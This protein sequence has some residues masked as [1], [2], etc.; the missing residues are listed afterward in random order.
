[1]KTSFSLR[2]FVTASALLLFVGGISHLAAQSAGTAL[3]PSATYVE[4]PV[5]RTYTGT[6]TQ[7][8]AGVSTSGTF[9]LSYHQGGYV[10]AATTLNGVVVNYSGK[11]V[12]SPEFLVV[13]ELGGTFKKF[14]NTGL[15]IHSGA[16][17]AGPGGVVDAVVLILSQMPVFVDKSVAYGGQ[18]NED[19]SV[20]TFRATR[21]AK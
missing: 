9:T 4:G 11:L 14:K 13:T 18:Q 8:T 1:M 6:A 21:D 10:E 7:T 2:A 19:G 16:P 3:V 17:P 15:L 5:T 20:L 12:S